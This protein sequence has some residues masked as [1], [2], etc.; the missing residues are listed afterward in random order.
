MDKKTKTPP[1][2]QEVKKTVNRET[3]EEKLESLMNA[4]LDCSIDIDESVKSIIA[5][6]AK[7]ESLTETVCLMMH[8]EDGLSHSFID[9]FATTKLNLV[10]SDFSD[11]LVKV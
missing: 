11:V 7:L 1:K 2:K 6:N 5:Y 3:K 4:L 10:F 9:E 8:R